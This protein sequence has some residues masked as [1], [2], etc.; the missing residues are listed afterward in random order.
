MTHRV[1]MVATSYPRFPGDTVGTFMEPI[2]AGI[3]ARG[4]DVHVVLPWH[5]SWRRPLREGGVTFHHF[6]YA[7]H[8]ALHV[9]GYAG[10]LRADVRLRG[11]ALLAAPPALVAGWRLARRIARDIDATVMHGHWVIPGGALAAWAAPG[12]PLVVSLHGSDVYVAERHAVTRWAARSAFSRASAVVACS[13]DLRIRAIR[14]GANPETAETL[15]YGVDAA[16]F[17]P[18]AD[19]RARVRARWGLAADAPVVFTAGR[20]VRK[21]GF[22][23]L[24]EAVA[25]LGPAVRLVLAGQ[26]DLDAE[27]RAVATI[28]AGERVIFAG[29]VPHDEMAGAL[30]AAD[31]VAVPSVRDDEGNVDGLPN[32][33]L[34][35]LAS[36]TPVVATSAGGIGSVVL[37]GQTGLLV[38]ERDSAALAAALA[39]LLASPDERARL[40]AAGRASML[41]RGSWAAVAARYEAVY[42][43]AAGC[44]PTSTRGTV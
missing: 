12:R 35:A 37:D 5:P 33:V 9:F 7:P 39:G 34:E 44:P 4:H 32:V 23:Y 42:H 15:P 28:R 43:A 11:S 30:A 3:A 19:A 6:H 40:G 22:E 1:V 29:L 8:R 16:R 41:A 25:Q 38:P 36:G 17:A 14:L 20:F 13:D 26:G 27:L 10:A 18:D 31:I 21:K 2:A 24:I